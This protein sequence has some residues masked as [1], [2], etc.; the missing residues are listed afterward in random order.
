MAP[1]PIN[2][3]CMWSYSCCELMDLGVLIDDD[4]YSV[5]NIEY[6][7]IDDLQGDFPQLFKDDVVLIHGWE[8]I[9]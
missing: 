1:I 2:S 7:A 4:W 9:A 3:N 6:D 8:E 5:G